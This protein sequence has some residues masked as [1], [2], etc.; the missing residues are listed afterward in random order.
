[1]LICE[2]YTLLRLYSKGHSGQ[3][4]KTTDKNFFVKSFAF[5]LNETIK[6]PLDYLQ[7]APNTFH[8]DFAKKLLSIGV[9]CLV[10][11]ETLCLS[12]VFSSVHYFFS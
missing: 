1:M 12:S 4:L 5:L 9:L 3:Q 10:Y 11:F 6:K 7:N 2:W 8:R